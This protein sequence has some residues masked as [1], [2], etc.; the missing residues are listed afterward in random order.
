MITTSEVAVSLTIDDVSNLSA[1]ESGL[2]SL[3]EVLIEHNHSIVC[4]VGNA[5]YDDKEYLKMIFEAIGD[6]PVRMVSMGGSKYNISLLVQSEFK[7]E[8]LK[9][10]NGLFHLSPVLID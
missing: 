9:R 4:I 2:E 6:I 7:S 3:G 10:L 8:V 5:L 1:I